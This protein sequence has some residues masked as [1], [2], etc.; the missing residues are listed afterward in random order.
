M[1][2]KN[3]SSKLPKEA[4]FCLKCGFAVD[5]APPQP[6]MARPAPSLSATN[7]A[8]PFSPYKSSSLPSKQILLGLVLLAGGV[9]AAMY[10]KSNRVAGAAGQ[11]VLGNLV[12]APGAGKGLDMVQAPGDAPKNEMVQ[13]PGRGKERPIEIEDYLKFLKEVENT[14][15]RLIRTQTGEALKM[16]TM[17]QTLRAKIEE[18]DYNSAFKGI[19]TTMNFQAED[20]NKL[21]T[22]FQSKTPPAACQELH[23]KYYD[24]LGKLQTMIMQVNDAMGEVASNPQDALG[25]LTQLQGKASGDMDEAIRKADD[26]LADVCS[27]AGLRKDFDI[28]GDAS[29][30]G[31]LIH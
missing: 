18:E 25:K 26:S 5:V 15:Q 28:R 23:D 9:G 2:C 3:C 24:H 6:V 14:K 27:K 21:T 4:R 29:S 7:S 22:A 20:W 12:N 19:N 10:F 31:G 17:A 13:T 11:G 8:P 30:S 16:L 1:I